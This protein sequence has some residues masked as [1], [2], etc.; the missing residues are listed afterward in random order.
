MVDTLTRDARPRRR[1]SRLAVA[2]AACLSLSLATAVSAVAVPTPTYTE[3]YRPQFHYTQAQGFVNDPNGLVY[4]QGEYHL[5]YQDRGVVA[6]TGQSCGQAWGHAISRDLVHWTELGIAIP[7]T[8]TERIFS[9]SVVVD[10]NNTSG[11]GTA[12][13]PPLVAMYTS[14]YRNDP[15]N[16]NRQAQSLAYSLDRGRTWTKYSGNPVLDIGSNSFR[17]PKVFW[18]EETQRWIAPISISSQRKIGFYSSTD[19]KVWTHESDFGPEGAITGEF[20]VPDLFPLQVEGT[21]ETKW[22]LLV[23]VN[24]G[25]Q[26][27]GGSGLQYFIGT[28]D[29]HQFIQENVDP[30]TAPAGQ[31]IF[32]NFESDS[33]GAWTT[34]GT[35]FGAGPVAGTQPTQSPVVGFEGA[36]LANSRQP[37][38][39]ATGTLT[40]PEFTIEK[41]Y[42]N[43]LVGGSDLPLIAGQQEATVN[44]IVD[45]EQVRSATGDNSAWLDWNAWDVRA[46]LGKSAHLQV[47]DNATSG[48][49]SIL[50]DQITF[51]DEPALSGQDRAAWADWGRDF[52]AAI[53]FDNVPDDRRLM[54]GWMS[55]WMYTR[56]VPTAPWQSTQSE[57]RDLSLREVQGELQL[58][59]APAE[60]LNTLRHSPYKAP[61]R[62]LTNTTMNL[63]TDGKALDI[64]IKLNVRSASNSGIKVFTGEG[65]ETVIG[66]DAAAREL[67]VDRTRSGNVGFHPRFSSVSRAPLALAKGETL[68]LRVLIDHMLVEVFANDG[69]RVITDTVFPDQ[70]SDGLQVFA[71]GGT[72]KI[73]SLT[74]WQMESIWFPNAAPQ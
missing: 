53:T 7:C 39:A 65:E 5:F 4:Y 27:E 68:R 44:L 12:D 49:G 54:I 6:E 61:P 13:N 63:P 46:L 26:G 2:G 58:F 38:A 32:E 56:N 60:E 50:L 22:V 51:S 24:P 33:Y 74:A 1:L 66:Y 25:A 67:Y 70:G 35:A 11:F 8:A 69:H 41:D 17:D 40:S 37:D 10:H 64:E 3:E 31:V 28:F 52:Y 15:V 30:Y 48:Q 18:H 23:N 55:N 59:Q 29:G 36:R 62:S 43:F 20:E 14:A 72:A 34:T 19:L 71:E 21:D 73:Q 42:L 9:G 45:G 57:P 47:V 16:A